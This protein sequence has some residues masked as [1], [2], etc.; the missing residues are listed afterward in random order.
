M[1]I[2][3]LSDLI[4]PNSVISSGMRGKIIR[5]NDRVQ[6][7]NGF[8]SI[9]IVW[10]QGIR[11][12]EFGTVPMLVEQWQIIES[13]HEITA[14]GAY[15]FLMF[16]PKDQ[17]GTP[18]NT[19]VKAVTVGT[20]TYYQIQRRYI[21]KASGRY[22]DRP[23]SRPLI[24]EFVL[25]QNGEPL[26]TGASMVDPETGRLNIVPSSVD[27]LSWGG[28]FYTPVHFLDDSIDWDLVAPGGYDQ[29][30][31]AGPSVVLQEIKE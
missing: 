4:L 12:Y 29:R 2:I 8:E 15:G 13:F 27:N 11:Q 26:G 21:D 22:R 6:T 20:E 3:V 17:I 24:G 10:S 19:G 14:G 23:I 30:F 25:Y 7:D 9:N 28:R 5:K 31:L 1:S 16:D 18:A